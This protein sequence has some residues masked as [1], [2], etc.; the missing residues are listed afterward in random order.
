MRPLLVVMLALTAAPALAQPVDPPVGGVEVTGGVGWLGGAA[1]GDRD[2]ELRTASG[3]PLT[4]FSTDTRLE[5]APTWDVHA[6]YSF[7]RRWMVEGGIS[8]SRPELRSAVSA[9]SEGASPITITERIDQYVVAGRLVVLLNEM[10]LGRRTIPF[11]A[12][13][14]GYVRQLH[15]EETVIEEGHVYQF[16]GGLKH[17]LRSQRTGAIKAAGLRLDARLSLFVAGIAFDDDARPQG[18]ISGAVFVAF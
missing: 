6:G 16:G 17:W 5:A 1:L 10:R 15:E 12:A 11:V 9:D 13:G 3:Q 8:F 4:L 14:V 18:A 2:A 7:G